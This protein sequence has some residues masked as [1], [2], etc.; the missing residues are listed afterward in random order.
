MRSPRRTALSARHLVEVKNL[1]NGARCA[2]INDRG[3]QGAHVFSRSA[4]P[5]LR[6][7]P[8]DLSVRLTVI[9]S[10]VPSHYWVQIGAFRS[11]EARALQSELEPRCGN[12]PG[13]IPAGSG[14]GAVG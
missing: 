11:R 8:T 4:P 12:D 7:R 9:G 6:H 13:P 14:A 3:P 10:P 5:K 2:R 1:E